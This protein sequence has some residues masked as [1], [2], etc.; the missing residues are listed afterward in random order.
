[1]GAQGFLCDLDVHLVGARCIQIHLCDA[2]ILEQPVPHLLGQVAQ[3]PFRHVS[4][5]NQNNTVG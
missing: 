3:G 5:K 2:R 1:M 4:V